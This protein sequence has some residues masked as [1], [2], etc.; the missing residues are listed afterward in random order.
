MESYY[1]AAAV[2]V[3]LV[4]Y[5]LYAYKKVDAKSTTTEGFR[6]GMIEGFRPGM[7]EHMRPGMRERMGDWDA[8]KNENFTNDTGRTY[9][10]QETL[11]MGLSPN[12]ADRQKDFVN[13]VKRFSSSASKN[14]E[15]EEMSRFASTTN[16][17]GFKRPSYVKVNET[18]PKQPE[19]DTEL[20]KLFGRYMI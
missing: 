14:T 11:A 4:L 7:T 20:F 13:N 19:E 1:I 18:N 17:L 5:Y 10:W 3:I 12:I 16:Y 9:N 2:V 15:L 6:P 8:S